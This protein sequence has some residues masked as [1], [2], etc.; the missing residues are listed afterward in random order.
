MKSSTKT[1]AMQTNRMP[2]SEWDNESW[3][4]PVL[5]QAK[6]SK[7]LLIGLAAGLFAGTVA[8]WQ[9]QNCMRRLGR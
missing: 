1:A 8:L 5:N 9:A 4:V 6:S 7:K 3:N 2:I